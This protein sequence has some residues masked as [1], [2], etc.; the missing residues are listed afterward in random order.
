MPSLSSVAKH[1]L[2]R[3]HPT[4]AKHSYPNMFYLSGALHAEILDIIF[5]FYYYAGEML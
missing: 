4:P 5:S 1:R 3:W 2:P